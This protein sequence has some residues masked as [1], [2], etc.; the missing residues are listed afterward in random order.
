MLNAASRRGWCRGACAVVAWAILVGHAKAQV[1]SSQDSAPYEVP[2][3]PS[4]PLAPTDV[5]RNAQPVAALGAPS[6]VAQAS[7]NQAPAPVAAVTRPQAGVVPP[8]PPAYVPPPVSA[9][10]AV[11][12]PMPQAGLV[13]PAGQASAPPPP[14]V[15]AYAPAQSAGFAPAPAVPAPQQAAPPVAAPAPA[16]AAAPEQPAPVADPAYPEAAALPAPLPPAPV[17]NPAARHEI[18][19]TMTFRELGITTPMTL[20]GFS[21]LQGFDIPV[22]ADEVVTRAQVVIDGALSPSLLPEASS[23]TLTLNEQYVGTVKVDPQNSRFGPPAFDLDPIFFTGLNRLNFH[24]AGE[25]RRDCN[26]L[27]NGVLWARVSDLSKVIITTMQLPPVRKLSRLPAP[28]FDPNLR[29]VVRVPFVFPHVN[30]QNSLKAG[31]IV[32]SW[33]GRLAEARGVSFP[34]SNTLPMSGNAVEV[35]ENIPVDDR[36][37][38]P[39]GPTVLEVA[40]PHDN[41]G[42]ILVVTGRNQREVEIAARVLVFSPD[43]LG[44]V[45]SRVVEDVALAPRKPYDAPAFVPT[46]RVVR[47][48]E[49]MPA[50]ALQRQGSAPLG[51]DIPFSLPPD[52]FSWRQRTFPVKL[53]V[54]TPADAAFEHDGSRLDVSLNTSYLESFPLFENTVWK[55]WGLQVSG[56]HVGALGVRAGLPPLLLFGQNRLSLD[57]NVRPIDRGACRRVDED[58]VAEVDS[59]SSFDFRGSYHYTTLPNLTYFAGSAFPFSRMADYSETAVVMP[60]QPDSGVANAFLNLMGFLGASTHYPVA[61]I[62]LVS[63]DDVSRLTPARDIIFLS[64]IDQVG[65]ARELLTGSAYEIN[66]QRV[67]LGQRTMLDGIWYLFQNLGLGGEEKGATPALNAPIANAGLLIGGESPYVSHRS[68]VA[69]LGDTPQQLVQMVD[70]LRDKQSLPAMQGD[71]VIRNGARLTYYRNSRQYAVGTLP[72]WIRLELYLQSHLLLLCL[73]S[74]AGVALMGTGAMALLKARARRRLHNV[75]SSDDTSASS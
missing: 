58:F 30:G 59:D 47:F 16:Y 27:H 63:S 66:G 53:W 48:G 46:D 64:T 5:S 21:P 32:A 57:F 11:P 36:G 67:R 23:L 29:H 9:P 54:R 12:A 42:T 17:V 28:F 33:L 55:Q 26:D 3:R 25:Y 68:V 35:G 45:S 44:D 49:I 70:S 1:A 15:P 60:S 22:P 20:R 31:G 43:T 61:G 10:S 18:T 6:P 39:A 51:I 65:P 72:R 13:D 2:E 19:R 14:P 7:Y 73:I 74:L 8:A 40:N 38:M 50:T 34:V 41:W 62:Q 24:F 69:V 52:L 37:S 71:L 56:P 4:A 75:P